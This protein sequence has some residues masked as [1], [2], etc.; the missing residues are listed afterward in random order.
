MLLSFNDLG[1]ILA[2]GGRVVGMLGHSWPVVN[3]PPS[4]PSNSL[5]PTGPS[6]Q[7]APAG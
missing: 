7:P 1:K 3:E 4:V 5:T 2:V 6:I